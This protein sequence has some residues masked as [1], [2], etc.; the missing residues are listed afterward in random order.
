MVLQAK[1]K[2]NSEVGNDLPAFEH[3][4]EMSTLVCSGCADSGIERQKKRKKKCTEGCFPCLPVGTL[5]EPAVARRAV[6]QN[7]PAW[8]TFLFLNSFVGVIAR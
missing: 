7:R 6:G 2:A 5:L 1:I 8:I 3:K 4:A